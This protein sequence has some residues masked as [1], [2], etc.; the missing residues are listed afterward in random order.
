MAMVAREIPQVRVRSRHDDNCKFTAGEHIMCACPKFFIYSRNGK[1][2]RQTAQTRDWK[3]AVKKAEE[4]QAGF[5]RAAAGEPEPIKNGSKTLDE[6]VELFLSAKKGKEV[7]AKHIAKLKFELGEFQ[8]FANSKGL[9]LLSHVQT[10]NVL[11][12]RNC[13]QGAQNTRAKKVFR[14]IGFFEFCVEMGW[15]ARNVARAEAIV[16]PYSDS[17]EPKALSDAQFNQLLDSVPK[18]NGQTTD[19]IRKKLRCLLLLMRWTGLA[20]R[21]AVTIERS[22][23]EPNGEGLYRLYL[24]RAKTGNP[25][26]CTVDGII[27]KEI[28]KS[29]QSG[30]YLFVESV[31]EGEHELDMLIQQWGALLNKKLDTVANLKDDEGNDFHFTS[32]MLRHTFVRWCLDMEIPI[33]DIAMLIGDTVTIVAKH[34]MT[35]ISGRQER[36]TQRMKNAIQQHAAEIAAAARN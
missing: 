19:E 25:V 12:Y 22:R 32:H 34:Y 17:Q 20:I 18:V 2:I 27:A 28:L 24:R 4:L 29:P 31:P 26:Y 14:L 30:R 9:V 8:K 16:V 7:T 3:E 33:E 11:A 15:I 1:L 13:L 5:E 23:F 6:A 21:D 35:W 10:E 36:L